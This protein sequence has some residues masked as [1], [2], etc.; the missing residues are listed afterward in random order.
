[1]AEQIATGSCQ[2]GK[3]RYSLLGPSRELHHCHCS[4]CRKCHASMFGTYATIRREYFLLE[5]G[6]D[7]L[8]THL[9]TPEVHRHFCSGCGA[10]IYIDVDW[11][12]DLV[13]FTP[14]T[15]DTGHP[16]H[17]VETE[18]HIWVGSKNPLYSITGDLPKHEEFD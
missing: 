1:M 12:P 15:L 6:K 11:E 17:P 3:I 13:W 16:Q 2:C 4:M 7:N 14:G 10:H 18:R 9:T 8:T 5:E